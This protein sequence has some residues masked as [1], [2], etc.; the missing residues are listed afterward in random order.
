MLPTD[1]NNKKRVI[2]YGLKFLH[3]NR[4]LSFDKAFN[5]LTRLNFDYGKRW[6]WLYVFAGVSVNYFL[7]DVED[8]EDTYKIG[9]KKFDAGKLFGHKAEVWPGYTFGLQF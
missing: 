1:T 3:L 8:S 7:H 6:R 2:H 4:D 5:I 9:S